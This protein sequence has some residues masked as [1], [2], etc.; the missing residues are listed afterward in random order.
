MLE[1]AEAYEKENGQFGFS[2]EAH[3][4]V[5]YKVVTYE[6]TIDKNIDVLTQKTLYKNWIKQ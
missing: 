6:Y 3:Y 5:D 1:N 2:G 4:A